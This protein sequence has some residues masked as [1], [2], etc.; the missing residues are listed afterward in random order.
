MTEIRLAC[1][2]CDRDDYDGITPA[3]LRAAIENGWME[4]ERV[5]SYREACKPYARHLR[6]MCDDIK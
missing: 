4:F 5:R 3:E 6:T 2:E 1:M